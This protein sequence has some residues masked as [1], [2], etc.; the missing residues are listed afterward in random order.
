MENS[1]GM[2]I[3]FWIRKFWKVGILRWKFKVINSNGIA[4]VLVLKICDKI[5]GGKDE[6]HGGVTLYIDFCDDS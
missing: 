4:I 3:S 6:K 5:V 1:N 2:L